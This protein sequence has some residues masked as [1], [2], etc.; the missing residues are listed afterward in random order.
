MSKGGTNYSNY[1]DHSYR[2]SST[3][4][5]DNE[6]R[7]LCNKYK[8]A[9]ETTR[10]GTRRES[11]NS[12]ATTSGERCPGMLIVQHG[13]GI[14]KCDHPYLK[15][16]HKCVDNLLE[17]SA[18]ARGVVDNRPQLERILPNIDSG[19]YLSKQRIEEVLR[20]FCKAENSDKNL[21]QNITGGNNM[22]KWIPDIHDNNV[23]R[24]ALKE[25]I[26]KA[27]KGYITI[28]QERYPALRFCKVGAIKSLP[29]AHSQYDGHGGK[30]HS[31]YPQSIEELEPRFRPVSIIVGLN[32]FNFMWLHD[33][34]SRESEKRVMTVYPGE[35]IMF[36]N[37]CLH[38][39]GENNTNEE[40]MRLFAYLVS[41][42]S[43]FPSGQ[44][45]TWDWNRGD[46]DPLIRKPSASF[47][48]ALSRNPDKDQI[49][50]KGG[51]VASVGKNKR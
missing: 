19:N 43:H 18:V 6:S 50:L 32:P 5:R 36:T 7:Y 48:T 24:V 2:Y 1:D 35:M 33:R 13:I 23:K 51:R 11:L 15:V 25:I 12:G 29:R 4:K 38:A 10:W 28:V 42:E 26:E 41:N 21:W 17:T 34:K 39:G 27:L 45:T 22:R 40:Q 8:I 20:D 31:D 3:S 9:G 30:F 46:D 16:E 37:H 49:R 47:N 44:V 14:A